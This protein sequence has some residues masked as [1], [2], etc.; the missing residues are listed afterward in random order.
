MEK[1]A[2]FLYKDIK[3]QDQSL[4]LRQNNMGVS[5]E[6]E[7]TK[8]ILRVATLLVKKIKARVMKTN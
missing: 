4:N 2:A 1:R 6:K 3:F 5:I 8:A 7:T